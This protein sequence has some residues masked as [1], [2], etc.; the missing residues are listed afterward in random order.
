MAHVFVLAEAR[1]VWMDL[2]IKDLTDRRYAANSMGGGC[3]NYQPNIREVKLFDISVP[4]Q[5]IP[6]L[7]SDLAPFARERSTKSPAKRQANMIARAIRLMAG[8]HPIYE[9]EE[10][11]DTRWIKVPKIGKLLNKI[12]NIFI[13]PKLV[14]E[15]HSSGEIRRAWAN[16]IPIG[17]KE[18]PAEPIEEGKNSPYFN[19]LPKTKRGG[20]LL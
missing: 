4:E 18:D 9:A 13:E 16:V 6:Q 8:F 14:E 20:E 7:L 17:W 10:P 15:Y 12:A 3:G 2:F 19:M 11:V 1:K 5:N